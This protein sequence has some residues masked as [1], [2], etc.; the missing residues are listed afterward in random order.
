MSPHWFMQ[1]RFSRIILLVMHFIHYASMVYSTL[2]RPV[3]FISFYV[4][5]SECPL[6]YYLI[7]PHKGYMYIRNTLRHSSSLLFLCLCY[8]RAKKKTLLSPF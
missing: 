4:F 2:R 5:L 6:K 1:I 3:S 8:K 7:D